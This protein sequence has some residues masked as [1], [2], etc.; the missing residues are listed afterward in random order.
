MKRHHR[1]VAL[2]AALAACL[3][4]AV[5]QGA[6][7]SWQQQVF[8]NQ[9]TSASSAIVRNINQASHYVNYCETSG[10]AGG[11]ITIEA[12]SD[13]TNWV[14]ISNVGPIF[15]SNCQQIQ[16]GGYW[17]EVRVTIANLTA[18]AHVT[19]WY[20]GSTGA[21]PVPANVGTGV[22]DNVVTSMPIGAFTFGSTEYVTGVKSAGTQLA[23]G[24][25]SKALVLYVA[26]IYNP[27]GA[28]VFAAL[29][30][31][32]TLY[33]SGTVAGVTLAAVPATGS[34]DVPLSIHGVYYPT[35]YGACSTSSTAAADP[36][37]GC[38]ISIAYKVVQTSYVPQ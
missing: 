26:T 14:L 11:T 27:N 12:S 17:P 13:H 3:G 29:G 35:L 8:T 28:A 6:P 5:G 25:G 20:S 38:I 18:G 15:A 32:T 9:A 7:Q 19:A 24:A 21:T 2:V 23:T 33:A 37:S 10:F 31:S 34:V 16:A 22:K 30:T 1:S 4:T 36:A